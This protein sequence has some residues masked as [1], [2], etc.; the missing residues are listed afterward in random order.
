MMH[1]TAK[2]LAALIVMGVV[3]LAAGAAGGFEITQPIPG[4]NQTACLDVPGGKTANGTPVVAYP[5]T[6]G[7][8]EQ[9][10]LDGQGYLE[11]I[12]TANGEKKCLSL[13]GFNG[14][15]ILSSC[16]YVWSIFAEPHGV[17]GY[18]GGLA[19]IDSKGNYGSGAQVVLGD[20]YSSVPPS[21]NWVLR[22]IVITQPI[23][24]TD[25]TACVDVSGNVIADGTP[26]TAYPCKLGGNERW[27]YVNGELKGV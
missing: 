9:W 27:A 20:C 12:G 8:N 10:S 24:N 23:P 18:N 4:T 7:V 16:D 21:R 11:S 2:H 25:Q 26:V 5:C 14:G 17:I 19:C 3:A 22:D 13:P 1:L 6:G 15:L